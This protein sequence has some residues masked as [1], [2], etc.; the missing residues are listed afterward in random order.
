VDPLE[1]ERSML[2]VL[3]AIFFD[4]DKVMPAVVNP[5]SRI[6]FS[7]TV[8]RHRRSSCAGWSRSAPA[9]TKSAC[10]TRAKWSPKPTCTLP[11]P[12]RRELIDEIELESTAPA[13]Y[14]RFCNDTEEDSHG[15]T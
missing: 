5:H 1:R 8:T 6:E 9:M 12:R 14:Y 3:L 7:V 10:C 2:H 13:I 4:T 15:T 11:T